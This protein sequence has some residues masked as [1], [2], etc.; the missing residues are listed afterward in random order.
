MWH[1]CMEMMCFQSWCFQLKKVK[2]KYSS[3]LKKVFVF[4]KICFKGKVL[5]TF[6]IFTDC[7]LKTCWSLKFLVPFL[8]R[9]YTFQALAYEACDCTHTPLHM[10][11]TLETCKKSTP[12]LIKKAS[13]RVAD[14]T[15]KTFFIF[16]FL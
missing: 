8:R 10:P 7:Y 11:K 6:R 2:K 14:H 12:C 3:F 15:S 16:H 13:R 9:T 4:Q 5:K 1:F